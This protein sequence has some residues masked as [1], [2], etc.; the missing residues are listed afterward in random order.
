M[1]SRGPA[2]AIAEGTSTA[3]PFDDLELLD[4]PPAGDLAGSRF[5]V[6]AGYGASDRERL[7]RIAHAA[8]RL[9]AD[10]GVSR[11]VVMNAWAPADRLIG[12]SGSRATPEVC[13]VVGASGAPAL[14]WGF[15]RAGFVVA[16]N[17]DE[18]A[19]IARNAD[20]VVRD[21][22]VAVIEELA[23]LAGDEDCR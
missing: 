2:L 20:V 5:L 21:D 19:P 6:V 23:A 12:V 16:V 18:H 8:R 3:A 22:G 13:L 7:A 1:C 9:G 4:A 14:Q 10:F 17:P 11:P 15:E